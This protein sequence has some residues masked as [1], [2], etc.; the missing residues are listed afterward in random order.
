MNKWPELRDK[1]LDDYEK[2]GHNWK[3]IGQ[4]YVFQNL[5][6]RIDVIR[7]AH[8][9]LL[10]ILPL[11]FKKAENTLDVNFKIFFVIYVGIGLGAGWATRFRKIPSILFGLE[12]I[13]EEKWEKKEILKGLTAHEIGHLFHFNLREET[14][15]EIEDPS[16][17]W[18]L[19]EEGF[20]MRCEHIIMENNSWHQR[21]ESNNW[22]KWCVENKN[23]LA[24]KFL[25]YL[26]HD[27]DVKDFFGSWFNVDGYKQTGY[28]LGHE[29]IKKWE[30]TLKLQEIAIM[31]IEN[32][33][34]QVTNTLKLWS[35]ED[36]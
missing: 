14:N 23:R 6:D 16:P 17:L 29:I 30:K 8:S 3:E 27:I 25:N 4:K 22:L 7:Q 36:S 19:Y 12:N 33:K 2:S 28:F 35:S 18:Q 11:I 1:Q 13:A 32:I 24:S 5:T 15:L 10:E 9:N 31:N 20:A 26:D 34:E 21:R